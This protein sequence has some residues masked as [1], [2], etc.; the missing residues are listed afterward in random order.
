[1]K[2]RPDKN[3]AWNIL[4]IL[5]HLSCNHLLIYS[6]LWDDDEEPE[7]CDK[8]WSELNEEQKAAARVLGYNEVKWNLD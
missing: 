3:F 6:D 8:Q 2:V 1:M 4:P 7:E 5:V